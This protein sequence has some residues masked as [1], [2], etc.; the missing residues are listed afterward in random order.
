MR[1][2]TLESLDAVGMPLSNAE[3]DEVHGGRRHVIFIIRAQGWYAEFV[4]V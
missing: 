1:N 2:M 4:D 3:L